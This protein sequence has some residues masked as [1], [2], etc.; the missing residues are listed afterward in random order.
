MNNNK[1]ITGLGTD[2]IAIGRF[3]K[4][5]EKYGKKFLDKIF[6]AEE[7][8][9]CDAFSDSTPRY[10]ARFSAKEA[11]SK[12]LGCGIGKDLGFHDIEIIK[13][14]LGKPH[15][16]LS[17]SALSHFNNPE[18]HLSLSHCKEYATA[19]AIAMH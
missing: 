6:T 7:Q 18:F 10:A 13:D 4:S 14:D 1:N 19:V 9:Y 11:V 17:K 8:E 5:I 15:I 3:S 16:R 2:I 12:A